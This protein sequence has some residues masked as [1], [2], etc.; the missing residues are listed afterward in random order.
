MQ[1]P[2]NDAHRVGSTSGGRPLGR[3]RRVQPEKRQLR[4]QTR[5]PVARPDMERHR[6]R[7]IHREHERRQS[8]QR[9]KPAH[10][11]QPDRGG[12]LGDR[13]DRP[14]LLGQMD[15]VEG[16]PDCGICSAQATASAA[17]I[18]ANPV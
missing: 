6:E 4:Q 5:T 1:P 17:W 11:G 18:T 13:Q 9:G 8:G 2:R 10:R 3:H 7:E 15:V 16:L 14:Q 12:A